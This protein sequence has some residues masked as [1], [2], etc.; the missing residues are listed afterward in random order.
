MTTIATYYRIHTDNKT[1]EGE[2][3]VPKSVW[4]YEVEEFNDFSIGA[5]E[6]PVITSIIQE[7]KLPL[8]LIDISY[9][10]TYPTKEHDQLAYLGHLMNEGEE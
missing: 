9:W 8:H 10:T 4:N 1:Y 5:P 3:E 7:K 2:C 6:N